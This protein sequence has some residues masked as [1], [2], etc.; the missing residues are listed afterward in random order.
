MVRAADALLLLSFGGPNARDVLPFLENVTR[1]RGVPRERL[2]EVAE[3]YRHFGG[4]S[5]I[6]RSTGRSF[7]RSSVNWP[8][9]ESRCRCISATGT[10]SDG[11]GHGGQDGSRRGAFG[12]GLPTSAWA[13][14]PAACSTTRTSRGRGGFRPGRTGAG[15]AAPVFRPPAVGRGVRGRDSCCGTR[16]SPNVAAASDWS[17]RSLDPGCRR[18]GCGPPAT[19]VAS[20][21]ASRR[22]VPIVRRRNRFTDYDVYGNPAPAR[23][24]PWLDPDIVDHLDELSGKGVDAVV[25]CPVGFVSDHLEVIWDLDNE[26]ETRQ[27]LSACL[28]PSR[29]PGTDPRFPAW[30]STWFASTCPTPRTPFG[31]GSRLRLHRQRCPLRNRCC[32]PRPDSRDPI[33]ARRWPSIHR[34]RSTHVDHTIGR[35]VAVLGESIIAVGRYELRP[36]HGRR[37]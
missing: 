20:I 12:L 5:P 33:A 17:S 28:R 13:D 26:A 31:C 15:E 24:V 10:G 8:L 18:R 4:V 9:P 34:V 2:D 1:G 29:D 32:V 35:V 21:A 23:P 3:H 14:T 6:N 37:R 30:S 22:A 27:P 19:A 11:C 16:T 25:V 36:G 7:S